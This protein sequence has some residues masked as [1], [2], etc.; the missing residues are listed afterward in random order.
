MGDMSGSTI[1]F[2]ISAMLCWVAGALLLALVSAPYGPLGAITAWA[3][4]ALFTA[5]AVALALND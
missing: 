1:Y 2:I 4:A 5:A 3:D